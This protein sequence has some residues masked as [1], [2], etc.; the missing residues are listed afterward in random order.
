MSTISLSAELIYLDNSATTPLCPAARARMLA[1]MDCY[2]NPSST[3]AAGQAAHT[4]LETARREVG[5]GLGLNMLKPGELIF[6][7]CG[8]EADN[9]AILGSAYAKARRTANRILT[10]DSEHPAVREPLAK[11]AREGF[12]VVEIPT[13]GGVLDL[14]AAEALMDERLFMITMMLVNNETGARYPLEQIFAAARRRAPQA[15][16][17]CDAVQGFLKTRFTARSLG[18]DMISLSAHKIGGPKGVGALWVDPKLLT[19]KRLIPT[20]LGGGQ[21]SGYRSGTENTV[22]IA[23]FGAAAAAG[24]DSLADDLARMQTLREGFLSHLAAIAPEVRPNLPPQYA[25]HVISLTMPRIKSETMLNYLSRAG[26]CVSAGSACSAHA[27]NKTSSALL[28]FGLTAHEADS[29][30]RVSLS[31]A[32][33]EAELTCAA[34]A[35]AEGVRTLIRF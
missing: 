7:A 19:A 17:H 15:I 18:A 33:T 23:G 30:I 14:D 5:R 28:A 27:K 26:I 25:P 11:L 2:G 12:E 8:S 3:H 16:L 34:E 13:R 32:T 22:G 31:P 4:L 24:T 29:T 20:L 10:T 35:I 1:A 6:T 21:E 9:L